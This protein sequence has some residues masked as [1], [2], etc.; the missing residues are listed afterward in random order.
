M[1]TGDRKS[2]FLALLMAAPHSGHVTD[3]ASREQPGIVHVCAH[4]TTY[5]ITHNQGHPCPYVLKH[6]NTCNYK[7]VKPTT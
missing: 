1:H 2:S 4:G 3:R 5:R 6:S 7:N